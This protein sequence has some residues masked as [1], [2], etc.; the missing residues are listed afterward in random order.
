[1]VFKKHSNN[2]EFVRASTKRPMISEEIDS[3]KRFRI[4]KDV[5]QLKN[6]I[7][8]FIEIDNYVNVTIPSESNRNEYKINTKKCIYRITQHKNEKIV[9]K[10]FLHILRWIAIK[11][12]TVFENI[13]L[14]CIFDLFFNDNT[15]VRQ[16]AIM[17]ILEIGK[18]NKKMSKVLAN[19]SKILINSFNSINAFQ[20]EIF[21]KCWKNLFEISF[22]PENTKEYLNKSIDAA[23]NMFKIKHTNFKYNNIDFNIIIGDL[24]HCAINIINS[25][26]S[27]KL[28]KINILK[29]TKIYEFIK[30]FKNKISTDKSLLKIYNSLQMKIRQS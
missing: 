18:H 24:L 29:T 23:I 1:M 5:E 2:S 20:L 4:S 16:K 17:L 27:N 14:S 6:T 30:K 28:E 13:D 25:D 8:D 3:N 11:N 15:I 21:M 9:L 7:N 19:K 12:P 22:T 10:K 26:P